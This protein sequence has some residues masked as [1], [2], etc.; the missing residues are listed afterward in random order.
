MSSQHNEMRTNV[1][2]HAEHLSPWHGVEPQSSFVK[3]LKKE[4]GLRSEAAARKTDYSQVF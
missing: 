2:T 1:D 4:L 3:D